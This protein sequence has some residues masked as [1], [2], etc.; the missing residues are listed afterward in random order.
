MA[1]SREEIDAEKRDAAEQALAFVRPGMTLGLGSGS[2]ASL[3][4]DLL[5]E[6]VRGGLSLR[7]VP[8]SEATAARAR[9]GGIPLVSPEE[10]EEID[11]VIDGADE[12]DENG[13]MIK[14]G[15][16]ALLREK[17]LAERAKMVLIVI[18][19]SKLVRRLGRFPLPVEVVPFARPFV[20]RS[21]RELGISSTPRQVDGK[22]FI[23]D[24]GNL[25]LDCVTGVIEDPVALAARL[26]GVVGLVEHGLFVGLSPV[27]Q[28]GRP[29]GALVPGPAGL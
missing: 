9:K 5:G 7:G 13:Q 20:E 29:A 19:S 4:I 22:P 12:V 11:L 1:R 14:G 8:S 23:T 25:I 21:L 15:G 2:T 6:R 3:V 26:D 16:G 17:L 24:N 28:V 10:A 27:L 18:D